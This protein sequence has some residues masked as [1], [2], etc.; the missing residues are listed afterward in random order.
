MAAAE[1]FPGRGGNLT[2]EDLVGR[3]LSLPPLVFPYRRCLY[4]MSFFAYSLAMRSN[5]SHSCA[6]DSNP[7]EEV[8]EEMKKTAASDSDCGNDGL[9]FFSL[10]DSEEEESIEEDEE[11]L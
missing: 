1:L 11:D 6:A 8:W 5:R 9:A 3:P 2:F 10:N 7:T 4:F